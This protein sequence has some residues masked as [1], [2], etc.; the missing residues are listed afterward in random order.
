MTKEIKIKCKVADG[1]AL[2]EL[3]EFQ[4]ELKTIS[5]DELEK[6]KKSILKYGFSFP[7]FVWENKILDGHQRMKAVRQLVEQGYK[8]K[9]NKLPVV[10]IE[11][12]DEKEAAEKLLLINSRYAKIDQEGFQVFTFEFDLDLDEMTELIELP[13]IDITIPVIEIGEPADERPIQ[14]SLTERFLIPPFTIF[15]ARQGYWQERKRAWTALG[16]DSELGRGDK[17]TSPGGGLMPASDYSKS[18]G[19]GNSYGKCLE[20]GIGEKYGRKEVTGTSIFDPVLCEIAYQWFS[21]E[22][23]KVLDP[24]AGGSVRGLV[25]AKLGR[26]YYGVDLRQEQI[27]ANYKQWDSINKTGI[28]VDMAKDNRTELTPVEQRGEYYFKRDDLYCIHGV[29]GGKVRT[30]A[31]LAAGSTGLVTA[32]SRQSPQANI[33]AHIAKALDIP[34][35]IHTPEGEL[36]EELHAAQAAGAEII[37]HKAGYNSVI[38][39]RAKKDAESTGYKYIPF[40]MECEEAVVATATQTANIPAD[41][42]RIVIPVGSGMSLAGVIKGLQN[43]G[44]NDVKILGISVGADPIKR[45]DKYAK[46]WRKFAVIKKSEMNYHKHAP[47]AQLEGVKLDPVYE[48]KCLPFLETG[49]MLWIVGIRQTLETTNVVNNV[50]PPV[51]HCGDSADINKIFDERFNMLFSCPPYADLEVY[52]DNENDLSNMEYSAFLAK[53]NE[54]I[55]KCYNLLEDDSFACWVVGEVRDR[56]GFYRNFVGNTI[57]AFL[58]AGFTYYNEAILIN[59]LTSLPIRAGRPFEK[60]RKLGKCHQNVLVFVKGSPVS[61]VSRMGS[62]DFILDPDGFN[63]VSN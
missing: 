5:D 20:T 52:S 16:I 1:M 48:A 11:A 14:A 40:G 44:R 12:K 55:K 50:Y 36:G 19:R 28:I 15:D 45:L 23:D 41:I 6:L 53:Y 58:D 37:Q 62:V 46:D 29:R 25:S 51:W 43:D 35:R 39:S 24:F 21:K 60:S 47:I 57:T 13:E 54:I 32:S 8:I 7:V 49:D 10:R 59:M 61:A 56:G 4:G 18:G 17:V 34:V 3:Y 30:C 22:G 63:S 42:K 9:D 2:D 31:T 27:D 33:V 38:I 26:Q